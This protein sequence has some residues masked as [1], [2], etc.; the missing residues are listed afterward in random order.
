MG[1]W[2]YCQLS[3]LRG[4]EGARCEGGRGARGCGGEPRRG[5]RSRRL[6]DRCRAGSCVNEALAQSQ[7]ASRE[8]EA[9]GEAR[10]GPGLVVADEEVPAFD[11]AG[12]Y[13]WMAEEP[14][15]RLTSMHSVSCRARPSPRVRES[16]RGELRSRRLVS[17]FSLT[18]EALMRR[19][20]LPL[21]SQISL[22]LGKAQTRWASGLRTSSYG[23]GGRRRWRARPCPSG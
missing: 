12:R 14:R 18:R 2:C 22:K 13:L 3:G 7:S 4:Y 16:E 19:S 15:A 11:L 23:R 8:L 6:G 9:V 5:G 20:A 1:A 17:P 21:C 10:R